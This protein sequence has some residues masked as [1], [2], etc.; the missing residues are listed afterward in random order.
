MAAKHLTWLPIST[1]HLPYNRRRRTTVVY[2]RQQGGNRLPRPLEFSRQIAIDLK[3][4]ADFDKD[5]CSPSHWFPPLRLGQPEQTVSNEMLFRSLTTN[6]RI[7][8][9][10]PANV[11]EFNRSDMSTR[12]KIMMTERLGDWFDGGIER[13]QASFSSWLRPA[14][15]ALLRPIIFASPH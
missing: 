13:L 7:A 9:R 3:A 12:W 15:P 10:F 6:R 5:W 4:D 2:R 8:Q 1:L 14:L 11:R